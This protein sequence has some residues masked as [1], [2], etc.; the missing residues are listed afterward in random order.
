MEVMTGGGPAAMSAREAEVLDALAE[1]LTNAEI[2]QRLHIS[3][4]T[5][6]SHVS[7]L[8]RKLGASDRREL[9]R[10]AAEWAAAPAAEG[11]ALVALPSEWTSFV[12]REIEVGAVV[13]ALDDYRL[14]TLLGPGGIGKTRLATVA[15]KR[16][17]ATFTGGGAFVDLVPVTADF[18]VPAVASALGVVERPQEPLD[19][20]VHERL[21][22]GR[23]LLVVDN[24]EHVL[25]AV[26]AFV[27]RALVACPDLAVLATSR[28]RLGVTGERV[29]PVPPLTTGTSE[30]VGDAE[31]EQLF[32]DRART[33][34]TTV[35]DTA[36][37]AEI[38]ERLDGMPL[39][40][41]LA[42][43]RSASL[44]IDG[45]TT[46]L[47]DRLRLLSR[48]N[49][50]AGRHRSLRHVIDW[51]HN[52]LE[53]DERVLF[54]RLGVFA[55]AFDLAAVAAVA[56]SG[57]ALAAGDGIARLTDKSLLVHRPGEGGSRWQ[58]L[59]TIHEYAREQLAGSGDEADMRRRHL[60]WAEGA[61]RALEAS[62]SD[63]GAWRA[64]FDAVAD[65]LRAAVG[66]A[67]ADGRPDAVA[68]SL[69]RALARLMY[70]RQFLVESHAHYAT[71]VQLAPDDASAVRALREEA[72][73]AFAELRGEVAF[74][75][76]TDASERARREGDFA[77]AAIALADAAAIAGRATATFS[78]R[79]STEECAA[80]V[81]E[82]RALAPDGDP[83]LDTHTTMAAAWVR[84]ATTAAPDPNLTAAALR[85]ARE[86]DDPPLL[87]SALD[88]ECAVATQSGR[89]KDAARITAERMKLLPRLPRHDPRSG[90]ELADVF[91]MAMESPIAAGDLSTALA[92]ARLA[93]QD[94]VL[95]H[96]L[97]H[98]GATH[99]VV[100]LALQGAFDEAIVQA[101][102]ML[103]GWDRIGRP[104]AGWM[105]ASFYAAA[106][107]HALQGDDRERER[108]WTLG[109]EV[110][111]HARSEVFPRFVA[112]RVALHRGDL[113]TA[114][115][116]VT[117]TR[118]H[119]TTAYDG[120]YGAIA[121]E[122]AVVAGLPDVDDRLSAL[123]ASAA[124]NNFAA[125][126]LS[127]ALG[128][129]RADDVLLEHAVTQW[130]AIGARFERA[131]TLL[132][133]PA[134][135]EEGRA[136]LA[137]LGCSRPAT[138]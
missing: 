21:R 40:I 11:Y 27:E 115:A 112:A 117:L 113:D 44:G 132:L 58:M 28:E 129:L 47:E 66:G 101:E 138:P 89:F 50:A 1:H 107:A 16:A 108:W 30:V 51:S 4:R 25:A 53:D 5:V 87:S 72:D 103:D 83:E 34:G 100:P 69:A 45:L 125:A 22:L 59:E 54:R 76:L 63:D 98:F 78:R 135:E 36:G 81:A 6:E 24:C 91:H 29:L 93:E 94:S 95:R 90:G 118:A 123:E 14:V 80:L 114:V 35:I 39:A 92:N 120:Y 15:A 57:D 137:A 46:A 75:L 9:A 106:L 110:G 65:D 55:G 68:F 82:A 79:L 12:G 56:T 33:A 62:L 104:A 2:A 70:A 136:E 26:S 7:S 10:R 48:T 116:Q 20:V 121:G 102:I 49:A 60:E 131:C 64:P 61:A 105:T 3:I 84:H 111:A 42:A 31:A 77:T 37:V 73:V 18:V 88:A 74:A 41:E 13:R 52:L 127:R 122:V 23:V 109:R 19:S 85:L 134:R 128:R 67:A 32:L 8:L 43:A 97:V 17:A 119:V 86:L 96:G 130:E 38:C 99:L 126:G 124:E 133:L 71:A